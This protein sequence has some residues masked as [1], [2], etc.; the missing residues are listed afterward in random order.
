[1][2]A[3]GKNVLSGIF[4]AMIDSAAA[5]EK[6]ARKEKRRPRPDAAMAGFLHQLGK[7]LEPNQD[8]RLAADLDRSIEYA[9]EIMGAMR[10]LKCSD[11]QELKTALEHQTLHIDSLRSIRSRI[12][13]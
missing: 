12:S 4:R 6:V 9:K 13:V 10:G 7:M 3:D 1:M 8:A 11:K 5:R 2:R